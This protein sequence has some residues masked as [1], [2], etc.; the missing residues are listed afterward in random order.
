MDYINI[1]WTKYEWIRRLAC[2]LLDAGH[3]VHELAFDHVEPGGQHAD[4]GSRVRLG[5]VQIGA[6]VA[7]E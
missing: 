7:W 2:A 3:P 6:A 4:D 1:S 5:G